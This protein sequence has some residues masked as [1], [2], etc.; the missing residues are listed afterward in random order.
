[1]KEKFARKPL[2]LSTF[3]A[4]LQMNLNPAAPPPL[5]MMAARGLAPA[6]SG[7]VVRV[8]Y[9]LQFDADKMIVSEA[10]KSLTDMPAPV[11]VPQLQMEQPAA[12]LDWIA[13]ERLKDA[14]VIEAIILNQHT[15]DLT[16]AMIAGHADTRQCEAI[17]NNQQRIL[18]SPVILEELYKNANARMA[19]IDKLLDL[20]RRNNVVLKG[21]P[22]VQN[23]LESKEDL[24]LGQSDEGLDELLLQMGQ[25]EEAVEEV[26]PY[27]GMTRSERE[28]AQREEEEELPKGPLH[29]QIAKMNI[30]QKIRA[31]TVGNREAVMLLV[32]E[33][34]RL[35]HMAAIQSPR[36]Q[37]SDIKKLAANKSVPDGVIR[38]IAN[39]REWTKHYDIMVSLVNNPK[40]PLPDSMGFLNHLRTND[41]RMLMRNRGV[42]HQISR[43]A[44]TLV[45]KRG[46]S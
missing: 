10:L 41:L 12:V 7:F 20:A 5:K 13:Q 14:A 38:Y 30:S 29:T 26:D 43:Q 9:Q 35:I 28:R 3:P 15:D 24:G 25:E 6:P 36:L 37:Y 31:A 32:R 45:T 11:L 19:T 23:A 27:E 34:N 42:S 44:K 18:R 8:L 33:G 21:L 40:T 1:M 2:D 4:Q 46:Q 16:V 22:G 39:N 17:S